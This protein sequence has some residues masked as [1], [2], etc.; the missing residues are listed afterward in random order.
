MDSKINKEAGLYASRRVL[1]IEPTHFGPNKEASVDNTYMTAEQPPSDLQALALAEHKAF[2]KAVAENGGEP[3]V[4]K[5]FKEEAADSIFACDWLLTLRG[6]AFPEGLLVVF[7]MRWNSRRIEKNPTLISDLKKTYA[8][9]ID[10]SA[11][12]EQDKALESIGVISFDYHN[13]VLYM[14]ASE[15]ASVEVLHDFVA[16]LNLKK[17]DGKE[18][19]ACILDSWDPVDKAVVFHTSMYIN[20]TDSTV[21]YGPEFITSE[22]KRKELTES[23]EKSGYDIIFLTIDECRS[24]C[25]NVLEFKDEKGRLSLVISSLAESK[26]SKENLE[27]L[28]KK[29][30]L[31]VVP[32]NYVM[33]FGGGSIRCS[34]NPLF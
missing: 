19:R 27:K 7:P 28:K 6:P 30:N 2:Q 33:K 15:R 16:Q 3:V 24:F 4:Y 29:Y 5:Q 32:Y 20:F 13:R 11:W 21:F 26:Y 1:L 25:S 9:F 22:E 12:E 10:L 34:S 17:K 31:L 8:D 18:F 23:F 14:N